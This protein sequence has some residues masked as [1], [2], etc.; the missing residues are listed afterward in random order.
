M[1]H[2]TLPKS[3]VRLGISVEEKVLDSL[4][5]LTVLAA[6]FLVVFALLWRSL[7]RSRRLADRLHQ[8]L[9]QLKSER[10][11]RP[12]LRVTFEFNATTREALV[13]VAN[14]GGEAA[15]WAA[16]SV[17]GS[18][19]Q[20]VEHDVRAMWVGETSPVVSIRRGQSR[21]LRLAQLDISVFPYAQWQVY[22]IDA[23]GD[24]LVVRAT[25]TSMIG[26]DPE[27]HAPTIFLQVAL[28]TS[29]DTA[30]APAHCT[31]ALQP[32]EAVRLRTG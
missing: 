19:A 29:P 10:T 25:H 1:S 15:V 5:G 16:M 11:A 18:L 6:V 2:P 12:A 4:T 21:V 13:R 28:V 27:T 3:R 32:F 20:R 23:R 14:D 31:V 17:E 22:G 24:V 7:D 30:G 9:A 8:E 26:G